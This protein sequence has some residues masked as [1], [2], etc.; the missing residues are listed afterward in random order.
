MAGSSIIRHS[1]RMHSTALVYGR[2]A[3]WLSKLSYSRNFLINAMVQ[4]AG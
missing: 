2:P 4:P 3:S 1:C